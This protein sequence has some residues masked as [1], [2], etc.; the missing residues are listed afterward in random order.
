MTVL[1]EHI[2]MRVISLMNEWADP[3]RG[4]SGALIKVSLDEWLH[5]RSK[6]SRDHK[7]QQ[8]TVTTYENTVW[9]LRYVQALRTNM[10]PGRDRYEDFVAVN[11]ECS[12]VRLIAIGD[13]DRL[14]DD[15]FGDLTMW[16]KMESE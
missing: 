3:S 13:K 4:V 7:I 11:V 10:L 5:V 12:T 6:F 2:T 1:N 15:M 16:G 8:I 9:D 14:I